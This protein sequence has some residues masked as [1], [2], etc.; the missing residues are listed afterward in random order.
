MKLRNILH[1]NTLDASQKVLM[2]YLLDAQ[3]NQQE[4]SFYTD[5][6]KAMGCTPKSFRDKVL[7]LIEMRWVIKGKRGY[8]SLNRIPQIF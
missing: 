3:D 5:I 1:T 8:Y 6:T 2:M 4:W 7:P